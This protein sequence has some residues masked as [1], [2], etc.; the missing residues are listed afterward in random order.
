MMNRYT[1]LFLLLL[2]VIQISNAQSSYDTLDKFSSDK[3]FQRYEN[4]AKNNKLQIVSYEQRLYRNP[5]VGFIELRNTIKD[6]TFSYIPLFQGV[7]LA[8]YRLNGNVLK[9]T[10]LSETLKL[11]IPFHRKQYKFDWWVEPQ[12]KANYG[13]FTQPIQS[14]INILLNTQ[15]YIRKGLVLNGGIVFPLT[16]DID[17]QSKQVRL[18]AWYLNQFLA[19]PKSQFLSLSAGLFI[20]DR[21]GIA[22]QYRKADFN[23]PWS[24]GVELDFTGFYYFPTRDQFGY[25]QLNDFNLLADFTYR[26]ARYDM[27]FKLTAGQFMY[28]DK[29]MRFDLVRQFSSVDIGFYFAKTTNGGNLGFNFTVPLMSNPIFQ[30]KKSRLRTADEFRFAYN[31]SR[32][33]HIAETIR[34]GY[35]LDEKLRKYHNDYWQGQLNRMKN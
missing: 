19:L 26:L 27:F 28:Q 14:K 22:T 10:M 34:N 31:Y 12:Y 7:P 23:K 16:N 15:F 33:Y 29:G 35:Q 20:N 11:D 30:G 32:G 4:V 6:S 24:Y 18:G 21:Y 17:T 5:L 8:S 3:V 1:I 13:Y 25:Y 2:F 9:T